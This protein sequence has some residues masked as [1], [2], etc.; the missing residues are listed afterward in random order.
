VISLIVQLLISFPK[1]GVLLL[2]LKREYVKELVTRRD[3]EHRNLIN[4][5]VRDVKREQDSRVPP[6]TEQPRV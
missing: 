3:N 6:K 1:I 5:W 4:E 2:K